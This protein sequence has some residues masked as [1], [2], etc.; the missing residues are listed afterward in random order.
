MKQIYAN[1]SIF[2]FVLL[3]ILVLPGEMKIYAQDDEARQQS[4]LPTFIGDRPSPNPVMLNKASLSGSLLVQGIVDESTAP[5]FTV[6]VFSN[7]TLVS[8]QRIKNRGAFSFSGV[9]V[10]G[11]TLT[12]EADNIEIASFPVGPLNPAPLSNRQDLILTWLQISGKINR[13]NEVISVKNLYGRSEDNQKLLERANSSIKEKKTENAIK[14]FK[15]ILE[16]DDNDFVV[17]TELGSAYF[18]QEKLSDAEK[19]YIKALAL[20][21]DFQPAL[22]NL[23][24]LYM[25]QKNY[26]KS[27]EKLTDLVALDEK[28][29]DAHHYLGESYLQIK[30]GS[31]A[32]VHLN[33]ALKLA[34]I[35]KAEIHLRLAALYNAAGAK[36]RAV[37]EYKMFLEKI[38]NHS[39][40]SKI[41]KYISENSSK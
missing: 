2:S 24:K 18:I 26:E 6:A 30:K 28:S 29:A 1:W 15:Q 12:V 10:G 32:V 35:E 9:P 31:T 21:N 16:K 8:R 37:A 14:L 19:S 40:K 36:D 27:I 7:G 25:H 13:N 41:E 23:A 33:E 20:K 11:I 34:P 38:P 22:L 5:S 39:E 17:W 3:T 4:G